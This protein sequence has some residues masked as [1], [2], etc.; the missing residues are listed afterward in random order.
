MPVFASVLGVGALGYG[1]LLSG[2]GIGSIAGAAWVAGMSDFRRQG[3][4]MMAGNAIYMAFIAVFAVAGNFWLALAC[5]AIA[6]VANTVYNTF[7]QTQL[8]FNIADDYRGRVL[9]LYLTFSAITPLGALLMGLMIDRWSAPPVLF[10][11][12]AAA[13]LLQ[14]AIMVRSKRMRAL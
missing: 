3:W 14:L 13:T 11:W 8:Q 5:L 7:N 6:G 10:C 12:C 1:V 2:V 9:A 4:A